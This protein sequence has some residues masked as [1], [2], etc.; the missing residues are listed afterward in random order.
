M[1]TMSHEGFAMEKSGILILALSGGECGTIGV[2]PD[3][4]LSTVTA[5]S[6][7]RAPTLQSEGSQHYQG[8]ARRETRHCQ[9]LMETPVP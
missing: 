3:G 7:L 9:G 5:V 2:L 4:A 1:Q 6:T 8:I